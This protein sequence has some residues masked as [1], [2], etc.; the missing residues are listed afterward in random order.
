MRYLKTYKN[1]LYESTAWEELNKEIQ[2]KNDFVSAYQKLLL[3][4]KEAVSKNVYSDALKNNYNKIFSDMIAKYNVNSIGDFEKYVKDLVKDR[5]F[6][7]LRKDFS[8]E[9]KVYLD[10]FN[11][12]KKLPP[13]KETPIVSSATTDNNA[14]SVNDA[15]KTTYITP[16]PDEITLLTKPNSLETVYRDRTT[17]NKPEL[18]RFIQRF[19]GGEGDTITL[20]TTGAISDFQ[21]KNDL[22]K[23]DSKIGSETW[24]V[25]FKAVGIPFKPEYLIKNTTNSN[26][27]KTSATNTTAKTGSNANA[28]TTKS[29]PKNTVNVST[30]KKDNEVSDISN[31][32]DSKIYEALDNLDNVKMKVIKSM[33]KE[34]DKYYMLVSFTKDGKQLYYP[35]PRSDSDKGIVSMQVDTKTG[36]FAKG[37]KENLI[38]FLTETKPTK[39]ANAI[40][41]VALD[42]SLK[43]IFVRTFGISNIDNIYKLY[44]DYAIQNSLDF[45][46]EAWLSYFKQLKTEELYYFIK[47]YNN[48]NKIYNFA[49]DS[50]KPF[51]EEEFKELSSILKKSGVIVDFKKNVSKTK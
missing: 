13:V 25:I 38:K 37:S 19:F 1:F 23:V 30:L 49:K 45:N 43:E 41:T 11:D 40:D 6:I 3:A 32:F 47:S 39:K 22:S 34:G 15:E 2:K 10:Y 48:T 29:E 42:K 21:A 33:F 28:G 16:T 14:V 18:A 24:P 46:E 9:H 36:K 31:I 8:K 5:N 50:E 26:V 51:N 27:D 12:I 7:S 17:P 4:H 20:E 44:H 35:S